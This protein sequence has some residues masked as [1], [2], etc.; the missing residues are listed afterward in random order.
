MAA[1]RVE[2]FKENASFRMFGPYYSTDFPK[3]K[4]YF[5]DGQ[6]IYPQSGFFVDNATSISG[7]AWY[8]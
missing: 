5:S 6:F 4:P 2:Y 7:Q 8:S 1:A 3:R